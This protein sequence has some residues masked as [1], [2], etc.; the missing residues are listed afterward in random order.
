MS[1]FDRRD[2]MIPAVITFPTYSPSLA[3]ES[4]ACKWRHYTITSCVEQSCPYRWQRIAAADRARRE[5]KDR[6]EKVEV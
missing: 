5:E 6:E 3:C 2:P 4:L 1:T